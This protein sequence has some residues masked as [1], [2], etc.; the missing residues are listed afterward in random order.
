M[1]WGARKKICYGY[2]G[3]FLFRQISN[4]ELFTSNF[5]F[6]FVDRIKWTYKDLH[7]WSQ[8]PPRSSR[9]P[10]TWTHHPHF[11]AASLCTC[12]FLCLERLLSDSSC[13]EKS[14]PPLR[15]S[16]KITSSMKAP[17]K[18][19]GTVIYTLNYSPTHAY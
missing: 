8:H 2:L 10:P 19:E 3:N 7:I 17:L 15:T 1:G 6:L 12:H 14:N 9:T 13:L 5:S 11:C 4:L 18:K 16:S